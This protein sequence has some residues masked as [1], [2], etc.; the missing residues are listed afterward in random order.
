MFNLAKPIIQV[1]DLTF[2]YPKSDRPALKN[3][4][5][6]VMPN[7]F[8]VIM[9]KNGAG[10]TTLCLTMNG[11]IPLVINGDY[12]GEVIVDGMQ[13][14]KKMIYDLSQT[15]GITLQDPETQIFC[16]DVASEIAFGPENIGI[17]RDEILKRISVSYTMVDNKA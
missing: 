12:S 2:T 5:F 6:D 9:G 15:V 13:A 17:P 3:V 14:G 8:I 11:V 1:K 16:P 4:T 10:K 7:E